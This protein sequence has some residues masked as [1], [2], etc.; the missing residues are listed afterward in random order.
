MDKL[1]R[2]AEA[3][4]KVVSTITDVPVLTSPAQLQDFVGE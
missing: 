4:G 3:A 2:E 1:V